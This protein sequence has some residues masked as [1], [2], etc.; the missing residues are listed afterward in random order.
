M[1]DKREILVTI[2]LP[3]A[4]EPTHIGHLVE[5]TNRYLGSFLAIEWFSFPNLSS[6][7]LL[8]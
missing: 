4:N 8:L 1:T 5:Y 2:A 7:G 6:D 3:Y